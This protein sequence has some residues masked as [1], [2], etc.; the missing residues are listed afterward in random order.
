M[1]RFTMLSLAAA[2]VGCTDAAPTAPE[3]QSV[4]AS[5]NAMLSNEKLPVEIAFPACNGET[6]NM[7][8]TLHQKFRL[9]TTKSGNVSASLSSDYNLSGIGDVTG[10]K[11]NGSLTIRDQEMA[12]DNVSGFRH[13]TTMKLVGQGNVPNSVEG[14]TIH[15][16]V[17]NGAVR[18]EHTDV[19]SSCEP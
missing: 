6:V 9:T 18:V 11:Y 8:G 19:T 1:R 14:F 2:I 4:A 17:A 13:R 5:V 3:L 7:S 15:V 10:A 12:T 16:V